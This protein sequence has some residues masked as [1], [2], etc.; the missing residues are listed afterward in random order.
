MNEPEKKKMHPGWAIFWLLL[1]VLV[2]VP[3]LA[4]MCSAV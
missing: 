1:G 2:V 3:F 4:G